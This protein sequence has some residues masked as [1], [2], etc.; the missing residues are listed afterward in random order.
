[1]TWHSG[2]CFG[3]HGNHR[4]SK[5]HGT[6]LVYT[7]E[8]QPGFKANA[9]KNISTLHKDRKTSGKGSKCGHGSSYKCGSKRSYMGDNPDF[10]RRSNTQK[11][12]F[13]TNIV[14]NKGELERLKNIFTK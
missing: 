9:E 4:R 12:D 14:A 11:S 3:F 6:K 5:D 7:F 1:M 10:G 2:L 13:A 8:N